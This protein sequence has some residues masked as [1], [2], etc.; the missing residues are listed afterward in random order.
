MRLI[1]HENV[2]EIIFHALFHVNYN[3]I[4]MINHIFF[5]K[6]FREQI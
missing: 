1:S 5:G 6:R 3:V 2:Y 4:I